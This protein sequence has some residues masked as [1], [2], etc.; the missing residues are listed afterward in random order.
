MARISLLKNETEKT[1]EFI[2]K[3]EDFDSSHSD[4][5]FLKTKIFLLDADYKSAFPEC[6]KGLNSSP[7]SRE[8]WLLLQTIDSEFY[9]LDSIE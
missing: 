1:A 7:A 8:L 5:Y 3:A 9:D 4:L 2:K 6:I